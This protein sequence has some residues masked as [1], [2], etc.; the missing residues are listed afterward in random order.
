MNAYERVMSAINLEV[1]DRVPVVPQILYTTAHLVGFKFKEVMNESKKMAKAL[2]AGYKEFGYDG[3][4]AGWESSFNHMAE[5]MG[6]KLKI[7]EDGIPSVAESVIKTKSD[8]EK[9]KEVDPKRD[10]RLPIHL[11]VIKLIKNMVKDVPIFSCVPGPLTLASLLRGTERLL[12]EIITDKG[13]VHEVT[14][15]ACEASKIFAIEKIKCGA[16]IIVIADP[17][18]SGSIISKE[19]FMEF[20]MPYIKEVVKAISSENA[21]PSVHICGN[22]SSILEEIPNSKAKI[23]EVDHVVDL[24]LAK[25]IL[26]KKVC[27]QGNINP[28]GKLLLGS[29]EDI[30]KEVK[31]CIEKAAENGGY[32]LSTGCEVGYKTPLE[33]IRILVDATKKFGKYG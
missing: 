24:K 18:A 10:G 8:I 9:L 21:I 14:K 13:F 4:Y 6:C 15:K 20:S 28:G 33:N 3:I 11:E 17:I 12:M 2:V 25:K 23:F 7:P 30:E 22:T 27:V 19:M 31:E 26:F 32:I 1:P 16:D 29:K 5:A